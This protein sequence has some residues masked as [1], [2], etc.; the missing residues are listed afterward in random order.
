MQNYKQ[1][2]WEQEKGREVHKEIHTLDLSKGN[3]LLW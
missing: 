1:V 2:E 3:F